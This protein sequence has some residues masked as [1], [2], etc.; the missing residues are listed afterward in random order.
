M[1]RKLQEPSL[2][3]WEKLKTI[4]QEKS[5]QPKL[6]EVERAVQENYELIQLAKQN[7]YNNNDIAS[8][9]Q[10]SH[11]AGAYAKS[12]S[13]A[14]QKEAIRRG[15]QPAAADLL[16]ELKSRFKLKQPAV[17]D[18]EADQF[19]LMQGKEALRVI[20]LKSVTEDN[21]HYQ[22]HGELNEKSHSCRPGSIVKL[23]Q[24]PISSVDVEKILAEIGQ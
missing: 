17:K 24:G 6:T 23:L 1:V 2:P 15:D 7:G 18:L 4:L 14:L 20:A 19:Y 13:A 10:D 22:L 8:W 3:D 9:L 11:I 12:I 5:Q 16:L 21:V